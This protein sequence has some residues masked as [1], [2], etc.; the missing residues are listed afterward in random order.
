MIR[1]WAAVLVLLALA[2]GTYSARAQQ[3]YPL[4]SGEVLSGDPVHFNAQGVVIKRSDGSFAPRMAWTN[5]TEAGLKE[6]GKDARAKPFVD[7]FLEAEEDEQS[8]KR[9]E[10]AITVKPVPRLERANLKAGFGALFTSPLS[11]VLLILFWG[12]NIYAGFEIALFRNYPWPLVCGI[13][14][15]VPIIGPVLFLCLPTY[16]PALQDEESAEAQY[17]GQ[18]EIPAAE[19]PAAAAAE[20]APGHGHGAPPAPA[21]PTGPPHV[22]FKRGQTTFNRRFFETKLANFLR[23]T[24]TEADKDMVLYIKSSRGDHTGNRIT[25]VTPND[26]TLHVVKAGASQDITIPFTEISE[27]HV[28]HKDA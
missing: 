10:T 21:A 2:V 16:I 4:L 24:P 8:D 19:V 17:A 6:L 13:A 28:K 12:A 20:G 27:V 1:R 9:A 25:R 14:A 15:V 23:V 3:S 22:V 26:L 11:I 5:F 18:A 7:Q